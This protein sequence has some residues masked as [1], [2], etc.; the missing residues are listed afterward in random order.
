MAISD[1]PLVIVIS[2]IVTVGLLLSNFWFDRRMPHY[3]SRKIGHGAGGIAYLLFYV[4][5]DDGWW[6]LIVSIAFAGILGWTNIHRPDIFRGVGGSGRDKHAISEAAFPVAAIPVITVGWIL[7][8]Q[9]GT[10]LACL[11][12]MAWGDMVTGI[13]RSRLYGKA[14]KAWEG[15]LAMLIVC[16]A[17]GMVLV[18]PLWIA[19]P[20]AVVATIAEKNCG[21]VSPVRWLRRVDDNFAIPVVAAL[22]MLPLVEIFGNS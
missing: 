8:G 6:A 5:F 9:P 20:G 7:L 1:I 21:D 10:V 11:L 16:L 15:S 19:I 3:L 18:D 2:V 14:I 12:F 13:V 22:V 17:I 4:F